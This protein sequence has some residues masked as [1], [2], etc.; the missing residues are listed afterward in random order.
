VTSPTEIRETVRSATSW[1][2]TEEGLVIRFQPY[3]VTAYAA[4]APTVTIPWDAVNEYM[5]DEGRA[6]TATY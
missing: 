2:F 4:G 6:I 1:T 5:S 3:E